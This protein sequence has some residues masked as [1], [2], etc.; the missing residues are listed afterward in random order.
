MAKPKFNINDIIAGAGGAP[1]EMGMAAPTGPLPPPD[2]TG[3]AAPL[4]GPPM[5]APMGAAALPPAPAL[6]PVPAAR[7]KKRSGGGG[8]KSGKSKGRY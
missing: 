6:P 1:P 2:L 3:G 7:P 4:G 5:G 8:K